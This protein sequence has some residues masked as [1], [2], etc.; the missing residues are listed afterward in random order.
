MAQTLKTDTN[1]IT[2]AV[3]VK[4]KGPNYARMARGDNTD[5]KGIP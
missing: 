5:S 4:M 1:E 3:I 2:P